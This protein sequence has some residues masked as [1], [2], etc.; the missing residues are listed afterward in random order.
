MAHSPASASGDQP[1]AEAGLTAQDLTARLK[2]KGELTA[3]EI[4]MLARFDDRRRSR[5]VLGRPLRRWLRLLG[6]RPRPRA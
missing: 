1:P 6:R 5:R 4:V 2:T 3:E